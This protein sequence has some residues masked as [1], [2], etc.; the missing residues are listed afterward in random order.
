MRSLWFRRGIEITTPAQ[1]EVN[2]PE[3][4]QVRMKMPD[5]ELQKDFSLISDDESQSGIMIQDLGGGGLYL[6]SR[7][8]GIFIGG[9]N[10]VDPTINING[11][12]LG[13]FKHAAVDRPA[14]PVTLD[15]V[16]AALVA[17]GLVA[18]T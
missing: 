4:S 5:E 3:T 14:K 9:T 16:I 6:E 18:G 11:D 8:G 1:S 7:D 17:L 15:D 2:V 10:G 13:F 12:K